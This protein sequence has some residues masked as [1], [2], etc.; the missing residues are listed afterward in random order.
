MSE[1]FPKMKP[2]GGKVKVGLDLSNYVTKAD[3]KN[4]TCID[5]SK[6]AKTIDLA[7]LKSDIDKLQTTSVDVS[8]L[9]DAVKVEV[10]KKTEQ[11]ELVK[12]VNAIQ[13]TDTSNLVKE[14]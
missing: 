2:L 1:Y 10:V 14:N 9:S 4:A 8:K 12:K 7:R 3:F 6:F 11:N 13:T 5:A